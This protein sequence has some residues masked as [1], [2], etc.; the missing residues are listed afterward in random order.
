MKKGLAGSIVED[1]LLVSVII[2][3]IF[4]LCGVLKPCSSMAADWRIT[5]SITE[6]GN[7]DSNYFRSTVNPTS[8]WGLTITPAVEVEAV[9]ERSKLSL[10]YKMPYY[11]YFGTR[12]ATPGSGAINLS[13]QDYLGQDLSLLAMTRVSNR[14]TTGMTE[15]FTMTREPAFSDT[16]S[17]I[18]T[19]NEYWVNRINPFVTYDIGEKGEVKLAYRNEV[20]T[21]M[22]GTASTRNDSSE[23][24]GIMTMTYN[25]N[26]TNHLDLDNEFWRREYPFNPASPMSAYDS[27]QI[28]LIYRHD[29]SSWL[30]SRVGG[31]YQWRYFDQTSGLAPNMATPTYL[32][33]L[34]GNN[35][36]TKVDLSFE[37]NMVDFT[38]A[39]AYFTAYRVNGF[40]QRLF[41]DNVI[42]VYGGGYY[43]LSDYTTS[44]LETNEWSLRGG[45]GYSFWKKR[46]ELS[47]EYNYT[48]RL[49]NLPG[50]GYN[51]NVIYMRLTSKWDFPKQ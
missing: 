5:P 4:G 28:Q 43:Q 26:S 38:V 30:Q 18:V 48:Q 19:R 29:L 44:T 33:G 34:T 27:Y 7:Y 36:R 47:V 51:D 31:G 49:S 10:S 50:F 41:F 6:E 3:A 32:V 8:V 13:S 9:T 21:F 24:R 46:M 23:N 39:D 37:H 2:I 20:L 12:G 17:Q 1:C 42:R 11:M 35:D 40:V 14:L 16:L 45:V 15:T 22:D 25:F